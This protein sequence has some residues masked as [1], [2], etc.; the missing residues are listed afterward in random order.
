V[1]L[2]L[3]IEAI[4]VCIVFMQIIEGRPSIYIRHMADAEADEYLVGITISLG[5]PRIDKGH[6][7]YQDKDTKV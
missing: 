3:N 4:V 1:V 5:F 2:V 6:S 7:Q